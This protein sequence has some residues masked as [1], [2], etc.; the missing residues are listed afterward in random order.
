MIVER[1]VAFTMSVSVSF[2]SRASES[3]SVALTFEFLGFPEDGPTLS[4]DHERFAYAGK[5]VM[6]STGKA[7]ARDDGEIVGAVAFSQDH[8]T[9]AQVRIRYVTVRDDRRGEGIGPR[10][11]GGTATHLQER[12]ERVAIAVNN[13]IAYQACY[14][15]GFVSTGRET[16]IAELLLVYAPGEATVEDYREGFRVF[17][18]RHLP[19]VHRMVL[20]THA[21]GDPPELA[22]VPELT[23]T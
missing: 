17:D 7:V 23:V 13:P 1:A 3:I 18:R 11:L 10:L 14:R 2:T 15:A 4:L 20:E 19:A 5:F 21:A 6:S 8:A 9:P 16:G 22:P 12:F